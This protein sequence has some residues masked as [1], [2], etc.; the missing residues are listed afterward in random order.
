MAISS[1][2]QAKRNLILVRQCEDHFF[3][4]P[5]SPFVLVH[6]QRRRVDFFFFFFLRT[7]HHWHDLHCMTTLPTFKSPL[8]NSWSRPT[9][10]ASVHNSTPIHIHTHTF[11][12][13][14]VHIHIHTHTFTQTHSHSHTHTHTLPAIQLFLSP[15]PPSLLLLY[16]LPRH[17][18]TLQ[19]DSV[20]SSR[21]CCVC[22]MLFVV[23][24]CLSSQ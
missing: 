3:V 4:Q 24:F 14:H 16:H 17:D 23:A 22:L 1:C 11:R 8:S 7:R 12:H 9:R 6:I 19:T 13:T 21:K 2:L 5:L 10:F 18:L 15:S 20:L